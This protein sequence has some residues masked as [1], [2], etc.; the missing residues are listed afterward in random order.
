MAK[1][2]VTHGVPDAFRAILKDHEVVYPGALKHFSAEEIKQHVQDAD[3]VMACGAFAKAHFENA[4][5]LKIIANYGAGYDRIDVNY[6]TKRGIYVTN[7]P[8]ATAYPTAETAIGLILDASRR[9]GELNTLVR[10]VEPETLFGM[11][12]YMG[13]GLYGNTLGIIGMGHIGG[14]VAAFGKL[15]G[16]RVLYYNRRRAKKE[17]GAAYAPLDELLR[18]SDVVSIHCPLTDETR[19]LLSKERLDLMKPRSVL[20]NT[21][22]AAVVDYD[23]LYEK[24]LKGELFAAG[25]DVFMNEPHI[26]K[27]LIALQNVVITPHIGTNT[28]EARNAMGNAAASRILQVLNGQI[29]SHVVNPEVIKA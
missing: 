3:A 4:E 13:M 28:L 8:D 16:M 25:L 15:M 29:P 9:I 14:I 11:G 22:R 12:R 21:A 23:A 26:P 6:A 27:E 7:T 10:N 17:N 20:V 5:R 1:I 24:L 18:E 19:G 2:L